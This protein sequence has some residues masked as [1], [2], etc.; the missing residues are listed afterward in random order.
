MAARSRDDD[1]DAKSDY[2]YVRGLR[3]TDLSSMIVAYTK[4]DVQGGRGR[5]VLFL[6]GRVG[7]LFEAAF[8]STLKAQVET[9]GRR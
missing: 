1:V 5:S 9:M 8:Q 2:V 6:D 3:P 7:V 4:E